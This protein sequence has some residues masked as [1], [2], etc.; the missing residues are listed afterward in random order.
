MAATSS[1][2]L[3]PL[4][5]SLGDL[6]KHLGVPAD[7]VAANPPPGT[8]TENDVLEVYS[9]TGRLCELVEGVLVEKPMGWYESTLA[10]ALIYFLHAYLE[11][12]PLGMVAGEAG[13]LKILPGQ[14]RIPDVSFVRWERFPGRRAPRGHLIP[15]VAPDLAVEILSEGNTEQEM[16]RKLRE[17]FEGGSRLVWYI[18]PQTRS[19][20]VYTSPTQFTAVAEDGMLDGGD[21]L[22]GFQLRLGD[23]FARAEQGADA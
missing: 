1:P 12:H 20:R 16:D 11:K 6:L 19:A 3:L 10:A 14:V 13:T 15:A 8:A 22:P 23:L 5:W 18:D 21:V 7:R 17:Y 2:T 9:R 4:D